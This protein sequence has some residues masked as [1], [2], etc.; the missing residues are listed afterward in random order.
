MKTFREYV[1]VFG[2]PAASRPASR[3]LAAEEHRSVRSVPRACSSVAASSTFR[4]APSR[5]R[6]RTRRIADAD[7]PGDG[8]D[9]ADAEIPGIGSMVGLPESSPVRFT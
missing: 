9:E 3:T 7:G 8:L 4:V 1:T 2:R 6:R 5:A